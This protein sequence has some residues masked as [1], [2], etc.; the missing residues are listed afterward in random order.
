[1][2]A[3]LTVGTTAGTM[4][5]WAQQPDN[6]QSGAGPAGNP[7]AVGNPDQTGNEPRPSVTLVT[8]ITGAR[9]FNP[10]SKGAARSYILPVLE[11][12]GQADTGL[13]GAPGFS[14]LETR[15]NFLGSL[16]AER[17]RSNSQTA[18][19]LGGGVSLYGNRLRNSSSTGVPNRSY[20][21][22]AR[23]SLAETVIRRRWELLLS[24][25][26]LYLPES[27]FGFSGFGGLG[28]IGGGLG[29]GLGNGYYGNPSTLNPTLLPDQTILTGNSRR[30]SNTALAE[31]TYRPT[32]RTAFTATGIYGLLHF[33]TPGFIDSNDWSFLG[34]Y[35]F[36]LS[37]RD[38]IG[39]N[40]SHTLS[41]F[42]SGKSRVLSRGFQLFYGRRLTA[43]LSLELAAGPSLTQI[44][45]SSAAGVVTRGFWTTF[46]SLK[47]KSERG[48]LSLFFARSLSGGAGV[49]PGAE[50]DVVQMTASRSLTRRWYGTVN[51]GHSYNQ[52]LIQVV[53]T[54]R[55]SDAEVW[56][57]G[58]SFGRD[59]GEN[60]SF[61]VDYNAQRQI[62]SVP[63]CTTTN[64]GKISLRQVGGVGVSWHGRPL[65]RR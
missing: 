16:T 20:A 41:K 19:D 48:D 31:I 32:A 35:N 4:V 3:L 1:V 47:Y 11:W 59:F 64:C 50:T 62:T 30:I 57:G 36:Q 38:Q 23:V 10:G 61:H 7:A 60:M 33:L 22:V 28:D 14:N 25:H 2:A 34:G 24:D 54:E 52:S 37:A 53:S 51:L 45:Q 5:T 56:M 17:L 39:I 65:F 18:L 21:S 63:L 55:R 13:N 49:L 8:P 43:R 9:D 42:S 40:Y 46:D 58:L 6:S 15:S 44:G 29:A 26:G 12:M 27:S